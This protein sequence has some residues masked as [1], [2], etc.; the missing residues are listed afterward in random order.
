[1]QHSFATLKG[2]KTISTLSKRLF[3]I[4][5]SGQKEALRIAEA[6]LLRA[7]PH[8]RRAG[9]FRSGRTVIV[10]A[11]TGLKTTDRVKTRAH[12]AG[13]ALDDTA[14]RLKLASELIQDEFESGKGASE[15]T[16]ERLSD[17]GFVAKL[18][19]AVP[20]SAK[21]IPQT[22]K[23]I[24]AS[25]EANAKTKERYAKAFEKAQADIDRLRKVAQPK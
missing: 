20:E 15:K 17:R 24:K 6:A 21:I 13:G 11:D 16:L 7:N 22:K 8:L 23:S 25:V 2:E 5:G 18:R 9:A 19:E 3:V 4:E 1:M 12:G 14:V 10:P